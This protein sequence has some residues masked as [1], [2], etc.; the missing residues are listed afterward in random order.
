MNTIAQILA[1][2]ES[3]T[4]KVLFGIIFVLIWFATSAMSALKKKTQQ[5]TRPQQTPRRPPTRVPPN[6]PPLLPQAAR[7]LPAKFPALPP[8]IIAAP[9]VVVA[10]PTP[11]ATAFVPTLSPSSSQPSVREKEIIALLRPRSLRQ[12]II[13]AEILQPPLALRERE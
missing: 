8:R 13:V 4:A 3:G 5:P 6:R 12:Q 11:V 2:K 7:R 9:P 10:P 1:Q